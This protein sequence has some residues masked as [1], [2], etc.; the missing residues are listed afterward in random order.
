[1]IKG[2][3]TGLARISLEFQR[4]GVF[5]QQTVRRIALQRW[6]GPAALPALC[7]MA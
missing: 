1:M 5:G 7:P 2:E 6:R 3:R 4:R